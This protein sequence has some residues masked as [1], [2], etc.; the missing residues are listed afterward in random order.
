[1]HERARCKL[2]R[3]DSYE[4]KIKALPIG[5]ANLSWFRL[6]LYSTCV[7]RPSGVSVGLVLLVSF[8]LLVLSDVEHASRT[9]FTILVICQVRLFYIGLLQLYFNNILFYMQLGMLDRSDL[10]LGRTDT[11]IY[12]FINLFIHF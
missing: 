12:S 5:V 1:M 6:P 4:T 9:D 10:I 7:R 8:R 2:R 3:R 11:F